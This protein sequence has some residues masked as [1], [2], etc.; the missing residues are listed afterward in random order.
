MTSNIA[1]KGQ[2]KVTIQGKPPETRQNNGTTELFAIICDVLSGSY[3]DTTAGKSLLYSVLPNHID[4]CYGDPGTRVNLH[5][6]TIVDRTVTRN[7]AD[8]T[9]SIT[10]TTTVHKFNLDNIPEG[11]EWVNLKLVNS[12]DAV[13]A[14]VSYS[15]SVFS[16][17]ISNTSNYAQCV[18]EWT[19][20]FSNSI[21]DSE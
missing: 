15:S 18:I 7:N 21:D 16:T 5:P 3:N 4:I 12:L 10:F 19:L 14:T 2:V 6:I 20:T 13:L 1:Y 8:Q 11:V 9:C 17:I